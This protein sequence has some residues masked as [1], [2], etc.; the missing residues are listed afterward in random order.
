MGRNVVR[1]ICPNNKMDGPVNGF[2]QLPT[3]IEGGG[4]AVRVSRDGLELVVAG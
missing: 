1:R 4:R 3:V 2:L